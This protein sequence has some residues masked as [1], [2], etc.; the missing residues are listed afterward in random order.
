MAVALGEHEKLAVDAQRT[1]GYKAFLGGYRAGGKAKLMS[2]NGGYS[3][4]NL[5][6]LTRGIVVPGFSGGSSTLVVSNVELL[7]HL[8]GGLYVT[9]RCGI[10]AK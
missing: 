2:R 4:Y 8:S 7:M 10:L 6:N 3:T 9:Q 1:G 5:R